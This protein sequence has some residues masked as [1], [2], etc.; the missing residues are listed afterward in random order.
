MYGKIMNI[1]T[2]N[3]SDDIK[4]LGPY[5][6]A[7]CAENL[8]FTSGRIGINPLSDKLVDGGL[9]FEIKQI[10]DNI[11][12]SLHE[13]GLKWHNV[14]KVTVYLQKTENIDYFMDVFGDYINALHTKLVYTLI[15]VDELPENALV[16]IEVIATMKKVYY[17]I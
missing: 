4:P 11:A 6:L 3:P 13:V 5:S 9:D 1:K 14:I 16:E 8:L 2:I 15:Q 7:V 12:I 10:I 17:I